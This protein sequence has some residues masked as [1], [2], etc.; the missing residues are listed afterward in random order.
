[1]SLV[2]QINADIKAAMIAKERD[3]LDALR[4]VKSALL[5]EATKGGDS[6]VDDALATKVMMKLHKQRVEAAEIYKEQGRDDLER[7]ERVQADVIAAYL[8]E[9]MS[10]EELKG[11]VAAVIQEV[12]ATG[13]Q[14]MGKVMGKAT[15][16]LAGKA[17]GKAISAVVRELL[18]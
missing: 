4:A 2:E 16:A 10:P 18:S 3:K 5:L 9:P 13:M 8:P 15:A 11:K 17:D 1:M 12:G 7:D 14:D 6:S